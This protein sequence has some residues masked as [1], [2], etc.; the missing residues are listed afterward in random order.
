MELLEKSS[1][2]EKTTESLKTTLR[3]L[4]SVETKIGEYE[5]LMGIFK[6]IKEG[7]R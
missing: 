7:K 2:P 5:N 6:A 1:Y 4:V 3:R